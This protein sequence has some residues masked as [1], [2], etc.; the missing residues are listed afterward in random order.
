[1]QRKDGDE[2]PNSFMSSPFKN[3][4]GR[5]TILEKKDFSLVCIVKK[6]RHHILRGKVHTIVP[7]QAVKSLLMQ[8]ELGE[9]RGK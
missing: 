2:K 1:M 9:Q 7:D 8:S 5:Y 3:T 6:F 4:E